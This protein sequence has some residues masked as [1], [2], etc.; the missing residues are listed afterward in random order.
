MAYRIFLILILSGFLTACAMFQGTRQ[1]NHD[2]VCKELNRQIIWSGASGTPNLWGGAT[3]D[4]MKATQQR[5]EN[6]TLM[7]NYR[8]EGCLERRVL[9]G[10][11]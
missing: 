10:G 5:A 4:P 8:E 1:N 7:R 6:E 2:A 11:T 3:G 9:D